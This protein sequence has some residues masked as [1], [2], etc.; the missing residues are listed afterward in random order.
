MPA[1]EV[2]ALMNG[3]GLALDQAGA[4]AIGAFASLAPVGAQPQPGT[5]ENAPLGGG[6]HAVEDHAASIG[7]QHGMA[8]AGKL[9]V[10][11]VHLSVGDLQH[12]LQAFAA[13]QQATMLQH[14]RRLGLGRV[15][16]IVLQATQPGARDRGRCLAH[17]PGHWRP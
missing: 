7:Q 1:A 14:H 4:D 3:Q 15:E 10:Q 9:L 11:A 16:M 6:G 13:F 17:W 2:L 8:S 5:L 12:L